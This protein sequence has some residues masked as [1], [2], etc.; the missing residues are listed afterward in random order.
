MFQWVVILSVYFLYMYIYIHEHVHTYNRLLQDRELSL[1][2]GTRL[3]S[4]HCYESAKRAANLSD[5]D[6]RQRYILYLHGLY[7]YMYIRT[8]E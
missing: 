3:L 6:M 1:M 7:M 5:D 4:E 8:S 2:D